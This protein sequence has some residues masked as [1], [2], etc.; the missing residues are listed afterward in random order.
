MARILPFVFLASF[1]CLFGL[2]WVIIGV[3]PDNAPIYIFALFVLLLFF[4]VWG[5][6]G[7]FLFFLRTRIY[8]RYNPD[9]YFRT[10]FKMA[11][12]MALFIAVAAILG[13]LE[14]VT[15]LNVVLA[16]VALGLFAVWSYLGKKS[17]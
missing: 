13:I 3:N 15:F 7:T 16:I 9:W 1:A 10:S 17:N 11:L 12:F 8:K 2:S 5:F 14:L 6:L 4:T